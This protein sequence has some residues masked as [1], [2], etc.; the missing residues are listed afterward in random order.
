VTAYCLD[1]DEPFDA[2]RHLESPCCGAAGYIEFD[3]GDDLDD[4]D[5]EDEYNDAWWAA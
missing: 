2:D 5:T 4:Y 3:F 1:C